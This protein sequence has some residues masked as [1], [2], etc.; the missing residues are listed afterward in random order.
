MNDKVKGLLADLRREL[1]IVGLKSTGLMFLTMPFIVML[2]VSLGI[3]SNGAPTVLAIVST[4][5]I[6]FNYTMPNTKKAAEKY[7]KL[8]AEEIDRSAHEDKK[9]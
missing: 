6:H 3:V 8:I 2:C 9:S 1:L 4:L 7:K 5:F